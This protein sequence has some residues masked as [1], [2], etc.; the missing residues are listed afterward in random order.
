MLTPYLTQTFHE[1]QESGLLLRLKLHIHQFSMS[2]TLERNH[3]RYK[4]LPPLLKM[5]PLRLW[6][7][8][9]AFENSIY[10]VRRLQITSLQSE[11]DK[12]ADEPDKVRMDMIDSKDMSVL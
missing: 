7:T 1:S 4:M 5:S 2:W 10:Q 12:I 3:L 8:F 9:L 6:Q 11:C